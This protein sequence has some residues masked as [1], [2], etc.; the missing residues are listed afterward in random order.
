M[1]KRIDL[2]LYIKNNTCGVYLIITPSGRRYIGS[3]LDIHGRLC[4]HKRR[5]HNNFLYNSIKKY[6]WGS[7]TISVLYV[8]DPEERLMWERIFGD[9]YLSLTDYG[10]LNNI[11]PGYNDVPKVVSEETRFKNGLSHTKYTK[12]EYIIVKNE[13]S[14]LARREKRRQIF[15]KYGDQRKPGTKEH[16]AKIRA[17]SF[18]PRQTEE[19]RAL[20]RKIANKRFE[21]QEERDRISHGLKKYYENPEARE[22]LKDRAIKMFSNPETHPRS[23][24]VINIE[25]NETFCCVKLAAINIGVSAGSLRYKLNGKV[26][27]NT[28]FKYA[29]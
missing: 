24:K 7:H 13:R 3:S 2:G 9:L 17:L 10:G 19:S 15:L 22:K 28:S 18:L 5:G 16:M 25:T 4:E 8:C 26:K 23:K 27:N 14:K 1:P 11:L 12:E 29:V 21:N 6:G 20:K